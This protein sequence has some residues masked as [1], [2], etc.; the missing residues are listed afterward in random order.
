MAEF[1]MTQQGYDEAVKKLEYLRKV[2]REE[3]VQ[4]IAEARSHGD[5]SENAEY[6]A[7]RN[8]QASN[9]RAIEEL[10]FQVKNAKVIEENAD[11]SAVHFGSV[12]LVHD[13]DF[14]EDVEYT[15]MGTTE[16]DPMKNIISNESPVGAALMGRKVGDTV[17]VQAPNGEYKLKILKIN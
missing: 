4:R 13:V 5:L 14:D 1:L 6:D 15:I 2:K 7:A 16:A 8:E 9:E 11:N 10:E 12:V 17:T 3:I